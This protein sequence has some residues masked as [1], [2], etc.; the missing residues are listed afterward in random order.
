MNMTVL[1]ILKKRKELY[2]LDLERINRKGKNLY[3]F[4][5]DIESVRQDT[6]SRIKELDNLIFILTTQNIDGII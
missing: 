4:I 1:E 5:N 3:A 2:N 6:E